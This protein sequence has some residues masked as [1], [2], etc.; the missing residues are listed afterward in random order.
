MVTSFPCSMWFPPMECNPSQT[1]PHRLSTGCSSSM[2]LQ[3]GSVPQ[4]LPSST[5]THRQH[6]PKPS[7]PTTGSSSQATALTQG[8]SCRG[9]SEVWPPPD[10]IHWCTVGSSM[11]TRGDQLCM[12]PMRCRVTTGSE[13]TWGSPRALLKKGCPC[14]LSII[15]ICHVNLIQTSLTRRRVIES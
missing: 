4:D 2:F 7:S 8:C 11:G 10:L 12:V 3:H 1:D 5:D 6:L 13:M 9:S 15:K 14:S